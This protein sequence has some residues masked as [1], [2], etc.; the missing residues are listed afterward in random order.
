LSER[1]EDS[2]L[3]LE[4][5]HSAWFTRFG[6]GEPAPAR[7]HCDEGHRLYDFDRHHSLGLLYGGHDPG[8]CAYQHGALLDWLLGY[9]DKAV[10]SIREAVSL[11]ERLR[12][13]L[14]L[15]H[16]LIYDSVL[17]LF[18]R[19]PDIA[20]QRANDAEALVAEQRIARVLDTNVLRGAALLAS[21][22]LELATASIRV[23]LAGR[24]AWQLAHQYQLTLVSEVLARGGDYDGALAALAEAEAAIHAGAERWW[25]AEIH[26]RKGSAVPQSCRRERSVLRAFARNSPAATGEVAGIARGHEPRPAVGRTG[27]ARRSQRSPRPRLRLVHRGL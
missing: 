27:A 3:R 12:H 19:E 15:S 13:P 24:K 23:G 1:Q 6:A 17:H 8:V 5:H 10:A 16:A 22:E 2:A 26:R 20:F 25:E 18:R 7:E 14:S 9:P 4:A 11:A 21:D